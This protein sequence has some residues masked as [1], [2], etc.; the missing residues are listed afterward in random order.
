MLKV[1]ND[2]DID[3]GDLLLLVYYLSFLFFSVEF[4]ISEMVLSDI[5][6]DDTNW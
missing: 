1:E 5:F 6:I 4:W 2:G 3:V